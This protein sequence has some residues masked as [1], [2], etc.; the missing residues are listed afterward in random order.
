MV[1]TTAIMRKL[2]AGFIIACSVLTAGI[3]TAAG[4]KQQSGS[5]SASRPKVAAQSAKQTNPTGSKQDAKSKDQ[6][7]R[8][9]VTLVQV[10]AIVTDSKGRQV[11]DLKPEDFQVVEDGKPQE[12]T[13]FSYISVNER[14]SGTK[15][16]RTASTTP[17]APPVRLRRDQVKRT[18][19]LV[20]NDLGMSFTNMVY[21]RQAL[22]KFVDEDMQPGDLV[23][24]IRTGSGVG[25]LQQ[26]T[27]DKRELYSA[28]E[29]IRWRFRGSAG[30]G[31]I[32]TL[33]LKSNAS[34]PGGAP[35][36]E[37]RPTTDDAYSD[38]RDMLRRAGAIQT[39]NY[40]LHGLATLPGRK[41][42]VFVSDGFPMVPDPERADGRMAGPGSSTGLLLSGASFDDYNSVG[43]FKQLT[44]LAN[45]ASVVIYTLDSRGLETVGLRPEDDLA[46]SSE[47]D[48]N[49]LMAD[50]RSSFYNSAQGM[51]YL[52]SS[53]GGLALS[54]NDMIG[55]I[56]HIMEDQNGY[57]LIGYVPNDSTFKAVNGRAAYH[58]ISVKVRRAGLHVR[59]RTGFL[60]FSNENAPVEPETRASQLLTALTS[61]FDSG[62]INL[63][64]TSLFANDPRKGSYLNSLLYIDPRNLTFVKDPDGSYKSTIDLLAVTFEGDNRVADQIN[65]RQNIRVG[66]AT[67]KLMLEQG[68]VFA[69]ELP[70]KK[71]GGYQFRVAVRDAATGRVGSASQFVEAPEIRNGKLA[72]SGLSVRGK[73]PVSPAATAPKSAPGAVAPDTSIAAAGLSKTDPAVRLFRRGKDLDLSYALAVY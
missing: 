1:H 54:S 18:V 26:F 56:G 47:M 21:V 41:A 72:L 66:E 32:R 24:I 17:L 30:L 65:T 48:I 62:G 71:G 49:R 36:V 43:E 51:E 35:S 60:G 58:Q 55:N 70:I 39:L 6:V 8:I 22:R 64:L 57:Y 28:I 68:F 42:M 73:L 19:A 29:G 23:A 40:V 45:R 61:P 5:Q 4:P 38:Q 53:T 44:D 34:G 52:A 31:A 27:A 25:A 3:V 7:V 15:P 46:G 33:Q 67:Y 63:R 69:L 37:M 11:T 10:D 13:N 14:P 20:V 9:S 16:A 2:S 50:R 12:I 59:S